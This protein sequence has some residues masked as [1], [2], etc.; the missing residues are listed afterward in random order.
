[1]P[2]ECLFQKQT[3]KWKREKSPGNGRDPEWPKQFLKENKV[4]EVVL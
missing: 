2:W 1:M 3:N 4:G